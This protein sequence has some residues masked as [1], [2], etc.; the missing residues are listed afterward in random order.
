MSKGC[1]LS[2]GAGYGL[3][4]QVHFDGRADLRVK[5]PAQVCGHFRRH[6][7]RQQAILQAVA[8]EDVAETR[9]DDRADAEGVECVDRAFPR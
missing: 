4:L 5:L 2:V 9:R 6:A 8:G 7:H 1:G 3:L